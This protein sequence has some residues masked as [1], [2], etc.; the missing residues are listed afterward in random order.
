MND[1]VARIISVKLALGAA[2]QVKTTTLTVD[3][4]LSCTMPR[5][6]TEYQDSLQAVQESLVLLKNNAVLPV[7]ASSLEYIVLVGE[8]VININQLARN[9]L[10]RNFD[11]IG[12][13]NGGWTLRWQG[14][15]GNSQWQGDNKA[16]TKA[17]SILDALNNL[18]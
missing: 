17:T 9:E 13:Q 6:T 10:F 16:K 12:M 4:T 8:R 1:A 2:S 14:F 15:E 7:T 3:D 5:R 11:N 18:G